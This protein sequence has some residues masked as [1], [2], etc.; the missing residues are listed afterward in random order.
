MQISLIL[1]INQYQADAVMLFRA[2][3]LYN[4]LHIKKKSIKIIC[5]D[6]Q[7]GPLSALLLDSYKDPHNTGHALK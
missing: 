2:G 3:F 6:S 7:L 5:D 4:S 1:A